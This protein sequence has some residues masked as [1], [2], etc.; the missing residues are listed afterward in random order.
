MTRALSYTSSA[1]G[2][3]MG[4]NDTA[5]TMRNSGLVLVTTAE[6]LPWLCD[7]IT[8]SSRFRHE[9]VVGVVLTEGGDTG[10][11]SVPMLG[12]VRHLEAILRTLK[13]AAGIACIPRAMTRVRG[14][15]ESGFA[16][17]GVPLTFADTFD[18]ALHDVH[19]PSSIGTT[20]FS[21]L[22]GRASH[23]QETD[24]SAMDSIVGKRVLITG[25]GGSIGSE[26]ARQCAH[27][28]ASHLLLMERSERALFEIDQEIRRSS[29]VSLQTVLHDVVD[30][31]GTDECFER[32][33]PDV[34]FHAAAHKHVPLM[35]DHPH[36][37]LRNNVLGTVAVT[38]AATRVGVGRLVLIST[39][40]A[41]HPSS[42]MGATKRIAELYVRSRNSV[43][44]TGPRCSLVRFGNVLGSSGSVLEVWRRQIADG[45]PVTVTDPRMTRFFMTIPEAAS[46]V[47]RSAELS[48]DGGGVFVLDMG[49]P[50]RIV[51]LASAYCRSLGLEPRFQSHPTA[52]VPAS[53]NLDGVPTIDVTFT[54]IR[55]GEKLHEELVYAFETLEETAVTG[56][57]AWPGTAIEPALGDEIRATVQSLKGV[58]DPETVL[59]TIARWAPLE[60][61]PKQRA[62]NSG[63]FDSVAA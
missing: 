17:P 29:K 40:K 36:E 25:A 52:Q 4:Q 31:P 59:E 13:P 32:F 28:G 27:G 15:I 57:R 7:Q 50:A 3:D 45:G 2:V 49:D 11:V 39:D 12:R 14:S 16:T 20:G 8:R 26:L 51:D 33:K 62:I 41:V 55:P 34:V 1:E 21:H 18:D 54:G 53:M 42:V 30:A 63:G 6:L 61:R 60:N 43:D 56:I 24:D 19:Q 44:G 35:E 23:V 48:T 37:A 58:R 38:D 47:I 46:L 10:L 5:T 9:Q 22:L